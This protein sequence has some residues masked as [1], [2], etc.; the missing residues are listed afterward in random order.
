MAKT[1]N[2]LTGNSNIICSLEVNTSKSV[3]LT[4]DIK[5][6]QFSAIQ[7]KNSFCW[8]LKF[9]FQMFLLLYVLSEKEKRKSGKYF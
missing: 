4:I 1:K 8:R 9:N 3:I 6:F 7:D 5:Y 2:G